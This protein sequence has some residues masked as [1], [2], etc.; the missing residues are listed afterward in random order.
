MPRRRTGKKR[1]AAPVTLAQPLGR[2]TPE[3]IAHAGQH[4]TIGAD[5]VQRLTD[6]P[7]ARLRAKGLLHPSPHE[8]NALAATAEALAR[9]WQAAGPVARPTRVD[10]SG[11]GGG[12]GADVPEAEWALRCREELRD[13][14][15]IVGPQAWRVLVAVVCEDTPL[16]DAG[17]AWCGY[18]SAWSA[19]TAALTLLRAGLEMLAVRW[20][21]L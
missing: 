11:A 3:R 19:S 4:H 5:G 1:K 6:G 18:R 2:A 10:L 15:H 9:R 8:N 16:V 21:Y 20:G 13:A 7:L 12:R 17:R 14:E